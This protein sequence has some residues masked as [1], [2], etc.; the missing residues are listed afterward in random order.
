MKRLIIKLDVKKSVKY[1]TYGN[2]Y[3]LVGMAIYIWYIYMVYMVKSSIKIETEDTCSMQSIF[4]LLSD[5]RLVLVNMSRSSRVLMPIFVDLICHHYLFY[6]M[7][8]K[9]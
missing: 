9:V 8:L 6:T 2:L 1:K 7:F 4:V 3:V 5:V